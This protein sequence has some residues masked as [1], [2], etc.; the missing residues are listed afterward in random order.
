MEFQQTVRYTYAAGLP[1]EII[2]DGP[3]RT[4]SYRLV[5]NAAQ[6]TAPI[7]FGRVFTGASIGESTN[8]NGLAFTPTATPGIDGSAGRYAGV[9]V[10]PKEHALYGDATGPL[11]PAYTLPDGS[12]G[13]LCR[14]G[15][16]LANVLSVAATAAG[17]QL[18]YDATGQITTA[19][20]ANLVPGGRLL[21][22]LQANAAVQLAKIELT[23]VIVPP[24]A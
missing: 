21:T 4:S 14:E 8:P 17:T 15:I 19:V 5:A 18:Y 3:N 12:W 9:L 11:A 1:G 6:P 13:E 24:A 10:S 23:P 7:A 16:L 22:A 20:N 2:N